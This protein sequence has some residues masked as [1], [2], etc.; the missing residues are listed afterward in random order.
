MRTGTNVVVSMICLACIITGCKECIGEVVCTKMTLNSETFKLLAKKDELDNFFLKYHNCIETETSSMN[1][2]NL[3]LNVTLEDYQKFTA[4]T[5]FDKADIQFDINPNFQCDLQKC[6]HAITLSMEYSRI[7]NILCRLLIFEVMN[8]LETTLKRAGSYLNCSSMSGCNC[9]A[10]LFLTTATTTTTNFTQYTQSSA[11]S[12]FGKSTVFENQQ[13]LNNSLSVNSTHS[14]NTN[15]I[16][17]VVIVCTSVICIA[18]LAAYCFYTKNTSR[19]KTGQNVSGIAMNENKNNI[20]TIGM[21]Q[22]NTEFIPSNPSVISDMDVIDYHACE[23]KT[24]T[25]INYVNIE[26]GKETSNFQTRSTS[27]SSRKY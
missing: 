19:R 20:P 4:Y 2:H 13:K 10:T 26:D 3:K 27:F 6:V 22:S 14:T 23:Q 1:E 7:G 16:I 25:F 18:V 9:N 12:T 15:A 8:E 21:T 17:I 5:F 24:N 11:Q